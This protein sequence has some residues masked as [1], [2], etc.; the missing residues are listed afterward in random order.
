MEIKATLNRF[1]FELTVSELRKM[2]NRPDG[3]MLTQN[4]MMYL[5]I[6]AFRQNCTVSELAGPAEYFTRGRDAQ[7][8]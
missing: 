6:I 8:Q 2:S 7:G 4:S 5:G 1:Y 3:I